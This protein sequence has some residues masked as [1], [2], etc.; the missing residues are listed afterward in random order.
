MSVPEHEIEKLLRR[1][2][3]PAPPHGLKEKLLM[4]IQSESIESS[5][6]SF[7]IARESWFRRWWP[8]LVPAGFCLACAVVAAVQEKEIR[9]LKQNIQ[10]LSAQAPAQTPAASVNAAANDS[11]ANRLKADQDEIA[12]LKEQVT[13]LTAEISQLE[14]MRSENQKLRTQL[15]TPQ[16]QGLTAEETEA[17]EKARERAERIACVNNLKQIGLSA[18]VF[19][20]DVDGM[21]PPDF[22]S[23]S[24]EL[25][26]PK[27]LVCPSDSAH[28]AATDFSSGFSSANFSY[29]F[30][31]SGSTNWETDP[32]RVMTRCPIHGTVGLCDGSV[33]QVNTNVWRLIQRNGNYYLQKTAN[34]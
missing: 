29:D 31:I 33:Q 18:R 11:P 16:I 25:G 34:P 15:A 22:L 8:T 9:A 19:A 4:Q 10:A 14:K 17:M 1:S 21:A 28:R 27:I 23:M 26:T 7:F 6:K 13:Q 5:S 30:Y 12:R 3:Q 24:N 32:E 2:P 20:G